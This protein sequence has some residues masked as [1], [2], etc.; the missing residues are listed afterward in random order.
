MKKLLILSMMCVFAYVGIGSAST[1]VTFYAVED[2]MVDSEGIPLAEHLLS[3]QGDGIGRETGSVRRSYLKFNL[4]DSLIPDN[5]LIESAFFGIY[6]AEH[7]ESGAGVSGPWVG[8]YY[9]G[10][11]SWTESINWGSKPGYEPGFIDWE[12]NTV[13]D[14]YYEWNLLTPGGGS[15]G[16]YW[17]NWSADLVDNYLS[18]MIMAQNELTDNYARFYSSEYA[19][20]NQRP[21]VRIEYSIIPAPSAL[22]LGGIGLWAFGW[23][24]KHKKL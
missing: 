7:T 3:T 10:N 24:R 2:V 16:S 21:Y 9:V 15:G 18:L 4:L 14:R 17:D 11:D 23:L 22:M 20:G 8:V 13:E 19:F 6:Q 5:A 1:T 12:Q